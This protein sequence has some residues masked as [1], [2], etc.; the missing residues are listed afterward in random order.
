MSC[1]FLYR[2]GFPPSNILPQQFERETTAMSSTL[3]Q[4]TQHTCPCQHIQEYHRGTKLRQEDSLNLAIKQYTPLD[5]I[6]AGD[7]AVT[8]IA[9]HAIGFAKVKRSC[10]LKWDIFI[11]TDDGANL[12]TQ[13][14]K[15]TNL[16]GMTY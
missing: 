8:I 7:N 16:Y 5:N 6:E 9:A 10:L 15:P 4:I 12:Q 14:R 2:C 11:S 1:Y 3:F 13:A